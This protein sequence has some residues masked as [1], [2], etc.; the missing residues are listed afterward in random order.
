MSVHC[1]VIDSLSYNVS[2]LPLRKLKPSVLRA[3]VGADS[4]IQLTVC[5]TLM[6]RHTHMHWTGV[7]LANPP[8]MWARE[9]RLISSM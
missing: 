1:G 3:A 5:T 9:L 6:G 8:H 7:L 2:P 4:S